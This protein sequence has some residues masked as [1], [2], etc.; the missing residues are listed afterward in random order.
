MSKLYKIPVDIQIDI[1]AKFWKTLLTTI[2]SSTFNL[3][4]HCVAFYT[5]IING[6]YIVTACGFIDQS[7]RLGV[8]SVQSSQ[9]PQI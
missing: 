9:Q 2:K 8:Y 3:I 1:S 7:A 4:T 5:I 6:S